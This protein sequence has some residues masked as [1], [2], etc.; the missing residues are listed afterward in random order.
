MDYGR[1]MLL[2]LRSARPEAVLVEQRARAEQIV[3]VIVR[4]GVA[5]LSSDSEGHAWLAEL[6]EALSRLG[7]QLAMRIA[8]EDRIVAAVRNGDDR[9]AA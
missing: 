4:Y 8:L 7:E 2:R 5:E 3:G 9:A 1:D 6:D